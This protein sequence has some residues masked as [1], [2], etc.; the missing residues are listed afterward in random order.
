[1]SL[2]YP[3]VET[4]EARQLFAAPAAPVP[5]TPGDTASPGG[6]ITSLTPTFTW[7]ASAGATRY[8]LYVR[9][10]ATNTLVVNVTNITTTSYRPASGVL[11]NNRAFRWNLS[12][13]NAAGEQSAVSSLR[14][15]Q[16]AQPRVNGIDV[17]KWQNTINWTQVKAAGR[18]FAFIKASEASNIV[19]PNFNTNR[20]NAVAAGVIVGFYHRVRPLTN[21]A[22]AEADQFAN[23]IG[24]YLV[25]GRMR[26]VMDFEDGFELGKAA[27]S[28]WGQTFL[29]RLE[30]RLGVRPIIY[31]NTNYAANY[32]TTSL[33]AYDLWI[34]NWG[35]AF[36]D[37]NPPTGIWPDWNFW[38]HSSTG[39]VSGIG[40]AV[41]LDV[42]GGTRAELV[43]Q[44]VIQ[45][46]RGDLNGD[47]NLNNLDIAPFVTAL[48]N[49][50]AYAA[51]Y[52]LISADVVGDVNN[53]GALNNLDISA[54]VATL[55]TV[56]AA[57]T[58]VSAP[59]GTVRPA[60]RPPVRPASAAVLTPQPAV[61]GVDESPDVVLL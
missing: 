61:P 17:S 10:L 50:A 19:D 53:D 49:P 34:A 22:T 2:T 60:T 26:P 56:P 13:F 58:A 54:F 11:L 37:G 32:F 39:T 46:R 3:F 52:P 35:Q 14:Y 36:P 29:N 31:A 15:F 5:L 20:V 42:F 33:N 23:T 43:K 18:E 24:P 47:G 30:A 1:M 4:L 9:D 12:A 41:D 7:Q 6:A 59:G 48:T 51:S 16:A 27:L 45:P 8:G 28:A 44:F 21:D 57:A 55:T 40:T 25:A 38:Q